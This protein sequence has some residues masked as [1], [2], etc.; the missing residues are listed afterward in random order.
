M[1]KPA[2]SFLSAGTFSPAD[3]STLDAV[4]STPVEEI[5]TYVAK[6]REAQRG[7]GA[8]SLVQRNAR[9]EAFAQ[10]VLRRADEICAIVSEETGKSPTE[11]LLSE[12]SGIGEYSA[13]A[14]KEARIA[15]KPVKASI[16]KVVYP[17]KRAVIEA[18]PRGVVGI[19]APWNYPLSI[20]YK[21]LFPALLSGNAVVLKP[22][23]FTP[24][25]GAWLAEVACEVLAPD[26]VQVVQGGGDVGAALI[27]AGIDAL[28]FTGSVAT[29]RK[30]AARAGELLIPCSV[31]LGG[32]DAAIVLADCDMDRTLV[33]VAQWATHNCG[34]N[35]AAIERIYIEERIADEF[36]GRL[37]KIFDTLR[38]VPEAEYCE[39]GPLQNHQQLAIV[40]D[41]VADALEKGARLVSGGERTGPGLGYRPTL[42]DGCT[43]EMKVVTEETF[44]PVVAVI[45]V[46]DVDEAIDLANSSNYGLNGSVWTKDLRRG[47]AL[48]RRL[49]VGVALVNNHSVTGIFPN[50]PWTG[51]KDTGTGIAAS[52]FSYP[53]Y[54]RRRTIFVDSN[55]K[56][57]PWWV[58][59]NE[60]SAELGRTLVEF[61]TGSLTAVF[62]LAKLAGKRVKAIREL[63]R[64]TKG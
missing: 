55:T 22:S 32:K 16:S 36:V 37:G 9:I 4:P 42:L 54:I 13:G 30:I 8:L 12:V 39:L 60:D 58:P 49:E 20:F 59:A 1:T 43:Q 23:E 6:A 15:L 24:R 47:E 27:G 56:P 17:G 53:T 35:C 25:T 33:G 3:L 31:E 62:K 34:Q 44:G 48:A 40:E 19:I 18:V 64:S 38:V 26:L 57:D 51:V 7:W 5:S 29:G 46:A 63:A 11:V 50:L 28:T 45:R 10:E 21:P 41:H 14:F 2:E 61:S 52:R